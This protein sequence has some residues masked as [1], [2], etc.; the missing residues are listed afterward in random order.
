MLSSQ[1]R[2]SFH[3][4]YLG[5]GKNLKEV[6]SGDGKMWEWKLYGLAKLLNE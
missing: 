6:V 2:N 5:S 1:D 3:Q 4:K